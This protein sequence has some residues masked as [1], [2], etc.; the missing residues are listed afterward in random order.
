MA[1]LSA[2]STPAKPPEADAMSLESVRASSSPDLQ[3]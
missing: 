3:K 1:D 2:T